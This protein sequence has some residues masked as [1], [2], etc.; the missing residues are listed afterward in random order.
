MISQKI[1]AFFLV[2]V[3]LAFISS[4]ASTDESKPWNMFEG[5]KNLLESELSLNASN[6]K[7]EKKNVIETFLGEQNLNG[8]G[9]ISIDSTKFPDDLWSNSS[10]KVLSE[11]LNSMPKHS[12]ATTNKIFKRLLLVDA[13]PPLNSIGNVC[14]CVAI[15]RILA[16]HV[17][18]QCD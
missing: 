14:H 6:S 2:F 11:K 18:S 12:L 8:I 17:G 5:S 10:E 3:V 7:L 9:L 15:R 13:K 1:R 16:C 4:K